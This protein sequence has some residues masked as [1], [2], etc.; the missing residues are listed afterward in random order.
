MK[1]NYDK[2]LIPCNDAVNKAHAATSQDA[3][4]S[5]QLAKVG[6]PAVPEKRRRAQ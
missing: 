5:L 1:I 2:A 3:N 4:Q 6:Q